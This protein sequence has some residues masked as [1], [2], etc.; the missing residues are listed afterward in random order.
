MSRLPGEKKDIYFLELLL[1]AFLRGYCP[2]QIWTSKICNKDIS[3]TITA[4][5]LIP[6]EKD[7]GE[8]LPRI[9]PFDKLIVV[10]I[11]FQKHNF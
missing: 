8:I 11:V 10:G 1:F 7:V 5:S 4:S 9:L 3:K 6:D 2:L